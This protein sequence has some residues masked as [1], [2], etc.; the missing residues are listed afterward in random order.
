MQSVRA[1]LLKFHPL[2]PQL[3]DQP[4]SSS[5]TRWKHFYRQVGGA[6]SEWFTAGAAAAAAAA[7]GEEEEEEEEEEEYCGGG[8]VDRD[9]ILTAQQPKAVEG[10][11]METDGNCGRLE[12]GVAAV[13]S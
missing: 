13:A 1:F 6:E 5:V 8:S 11:W 7:G 12:R 4:Q 3:M 9:S 2:L 10:E